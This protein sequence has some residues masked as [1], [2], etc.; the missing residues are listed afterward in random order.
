[1][2][3][4]NLGEALDRIE[5]SVEQLQTRVAALE[6]EKSSLLARQESL[7]AER[8]GLVQKNEEARSRVHAMIER[9]KQ[10]ESA[11]A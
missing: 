11:G 6:R 9:L 5:A 10:L 1:M 2:S 7:V 3:I 8:A 4:R